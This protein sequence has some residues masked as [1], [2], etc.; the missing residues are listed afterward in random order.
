MDRKKYDEEFYI[1]MEADEQL[2]AEG[3]VKAYIL[4]G[5]LAALQMACDHREGG[6][7]LEQFIETITASIDKTITTGELDETA[8]KICTDIDDADDGS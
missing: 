2:E 1:K 7:N 6:L 8:F 5:Q 3:L 4:A